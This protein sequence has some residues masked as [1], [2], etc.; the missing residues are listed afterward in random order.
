MLVFNKDEIRESLTLENIYS[1]LTEFGGE[2]EYTSFGIRSITI[3]HNRPGESASRKLYYYLNSQLFQCYTGCSEYFDVFQLVIKVANLQW[4]LEYSLYQAVKWIASKFNIS[5]QLEEEKEK[6]LEDWEYFSA[7]DRLKEI[8]VINKD[9]ILESYNPAILNNLNYEVKIMPW[10]REGISEE[11][12]KAA[13]I[14]FYP[15]GDQITIPHYDENGRFIGLR[16]R[17]LSITEG[18]N[19]GKYRPLRINNTLYNHPLGLNLY[20]LNHSKNNIKA[21]GKAIVFEGEKATLQYRSYFGEENDISVACC[22]FNVSSYQMELLMRNGAKE[23]VIAF[24]K[25]FQKIGDEEFQR[26]KRKITNI[27]QKYKNYVNLSFIFDK[28]MKT[29]YK[30]SPTDKG[31]EIF[32]ELFKERIML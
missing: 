15:G 29:E 8:S 11:V 2:P 7:Y 23:I 10:I 18:L 12:M 1:L 5:G 22:G 13:N 16:G 4:N 21:Y 6:G 19:Y 30:D 24:D 32:K 20:N 17:T 31:A 14:G 9:I 27:H 25:Q 28:T 3:C 26:L